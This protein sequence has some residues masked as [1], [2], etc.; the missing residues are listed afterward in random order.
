MPMLNTLRAAPKV[1][2]EERLV[3]LICVLLV[4]VMLS[5]FIAASARRAQG[6]AIN[7]S[8][9]LVTWHPLMM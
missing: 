9:K 2:S 4:T 1:I 3:T 8:T 5:S 7:V 6:E